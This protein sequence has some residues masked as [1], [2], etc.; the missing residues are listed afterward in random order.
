MKCDYNRSQSHEPPNV[1]IAKRS[2]AMGAGQR[3][4]VCPAA[5]GTIEMP[6]FIELSSL[7]IYSYVLEVRVLVR[8]A[9]RLPVQESSGK[10]IYW[11]PSKL[12]RATKITFSE[13]HSVITRR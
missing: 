8:C 4:T 11:L 1:S 5:V 7:H 3:L 10:A 12:T 9:A 2:L 6:H 13:E